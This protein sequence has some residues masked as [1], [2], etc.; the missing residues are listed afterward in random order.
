MLLSLLLGNVYDDDDDDDEVDDDD[1]DDEVDDGDYDDN[2]DGSTVWKKKKGEQLTV[3]E[4]YAMLMLASILSWYIIS[5]EVPTKGDS[6]WGK[7]V[8]IC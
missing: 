6:C 2:G 8:S 7:F 1:N 5:H 4:P 3:E